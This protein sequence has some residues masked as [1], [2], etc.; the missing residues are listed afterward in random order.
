MEGPSRGH[1]GVSPGETRDRRLQLAMIGAIAGDEGQR[2]PARMRSRDPEIVAGGFRIGRV[3]VVLE[4]YAGRRRARR[5]HPDAVSS[6][7]RS[8]LDL[9]GAGVCGSDDRADSRSIAPRGFRARCARTRP[10]PLPDAASIARR[11]TT[12]ETGARTMSALPAA[13]GGL[14]PGERA[15][16]VIEALLA[17]AAP[18]ARVVRDGHALELPA[19]ECRLGSSV[20]PSRHI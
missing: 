11:A 2:V 5:W 19:S 12:I 10:P 13:F 1:R 18:S 9:D 6:R 17:R 20:A 15:D 14:R 7:L 8:L 16:R 4:G 3:R